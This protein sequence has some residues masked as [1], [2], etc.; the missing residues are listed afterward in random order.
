MSQHRGILN[1]E[2]IEHEIELK[3]ETKMLVGNIDEGVLV[4]EA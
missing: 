2:M 1:N 3:I 4:I